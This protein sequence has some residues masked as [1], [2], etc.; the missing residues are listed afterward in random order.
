LEQAEIEDPRGNQLIQVHLEKGCRM[1]AVVP[2]LGEHCTWNSDIRSCHTLHTFK[3]TSEHTCSVSLNLKPPAP[4]YPL[5]VFKAL[6]KCCIIIII[7][8]RW[9]SSRL[10][11]NIAAEI[12]CGQISFLMSTGR[13]NHYTSLHFTRVVDDA[14]CIVVTRVCV[15]L[16]VRGRM[17]TLLHRP[18]CNLGEWYGMPLVVHY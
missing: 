11:G 9:S 15:C 1:E 13:N 3:N 10:R 4:P 18:R 5:Q 7:I 16:S 6:Y 14:K 17:P 12:L 8:N 2:V